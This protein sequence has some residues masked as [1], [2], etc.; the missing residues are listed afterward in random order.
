MIYCSK[1]KTN[2]KEKNKNKKNL[3]IIN[4]IVVATSY[5]FFESTTCKLFLCIRQI[6]FFQKFFF[7]KTNSHSNFFQ[8]KS[9]HHSTRCR[10]NLWYYLLSSKWQLNFS[11]SKA[12][13]Q[14][15]DCFSI[16]N[17]T[18]HFSSILHSSFSHHCSFFRFHFYYSK[19]TTRNSKKRKKKY[20]Q[21]RNRRQ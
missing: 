10:K 21:S 4:L 8:K 1:T 13:H 11:K 18:F 9:H 5:E 14:R 15:I 3:F 17:Q 6:R 7:I 20:F 12:L 2:T 16:S 19:R